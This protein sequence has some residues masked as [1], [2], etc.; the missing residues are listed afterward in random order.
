VSVVVRF[1]PKNVTREKYD[2]VIRRLEAAGEWPHPPGLE[3]HV[4]YGSEGSLRVSE[5]WDSPE[6]LE[7]YF[8]KIGPIMGDVGIEMASEPEIFEVHNIVKR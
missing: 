5:I 3:F 4:L 1:N 8:Q 6:S 2:E 7:A